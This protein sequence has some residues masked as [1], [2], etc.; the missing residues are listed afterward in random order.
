M[1][2]N[3]SSQR[4]TNTQ[5][6]LNILM[7]NGYHLETISQVIGVNQETIKHYINN[8]EE[9]NPSIFERL[10]IFYCKFTVSKKKTI[11]T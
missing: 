11:V 3:Q 2:A 9:I 4:S 1:L 8:H 6:M 7:Q 5:Y 10:L